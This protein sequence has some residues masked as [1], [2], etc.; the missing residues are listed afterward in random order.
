MASTW[1]SVS[2]NAAAVRPPLRP[3]VLRS[4]FLTLRMPSLVSKQTFDGTNERAPKRRLDGGT[5]N[6][7]ASFRH[8]HGL[9][10]GMTIGR[11]VRINDERMPGRGSAA[12]TDCPPAPSNRYGHLA[13]RGRLALAG[14]LIASGIGFAACGSDDE[15]PSASGPILDP[16]P[17]VSSASVVTDPGDSGLCTTTVVFIRR[18]CA[19][20]CTR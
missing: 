4:S 1:S 13:S 18:N 7:R 11:S 12:G 20:S 17:A 9:Y 5:P 16:R 15:A 6:V 3:S 14:L 10:R 2:T 8:R 19:E